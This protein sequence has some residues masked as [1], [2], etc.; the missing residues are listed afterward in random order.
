MVKESIKYRFKYLPKARGNLF[1]T[2]SQ[3]LSS[4]VLSQ[5]G[6]IRAPSCYELVK[7]LNLILD[8]AFSNEKCFVYFNY[9]SKGVLCY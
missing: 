1:Q 7:P 6:E 5:R 8:S 4:C 9:A 2:S 3:I